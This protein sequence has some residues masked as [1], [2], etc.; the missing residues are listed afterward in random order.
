M[1]AGH[2]PIRHRTR[3]TIPPL[4][5]I[6][7]RYVQLLDFTLKDSCPRYRYETKKSTTVQGRMIEQVV[8]ARESVA[9]TFYTGLQALV[10]II[11]HL[12]HSGPRRCKGIHPQLSCPASAWRRGLLV[13]SGPARTTEAT[14]KGPASIDRPD[15]PLPPSQAVFTSPS[16]RDEAE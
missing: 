10:G 12:L 7:L 16:Y 8:V 3:F 14:Q 9:A 2:C 13:R 11:D 5:L 1:P 15:T 4:P 6:K